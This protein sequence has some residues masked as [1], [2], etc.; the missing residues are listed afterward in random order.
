MTASLIAP[1]LILSIFEHQEPRFLIPLIVPLVYLNAHD[2]FPD[3]H[4]IVVATSKQIAKPAN[5]EKKPENPRHLLFK[6][7]LVLNVILSLFYGFIHQGGVFKATS[8]LSEELNSKPIN[9]NF[10][11]VTSHIYSMPKSLFLQKSSEKLYYNNKFKYKLNKRLFMYEEGSNNL[12]TVL[13]TL[14]ILRSSSNRTVIVYFVFP[15]S[16][17]V[18]IDYNLNN[19]GIKLENCVSFFPHVS[20][21]ALPTI[22]SFVPLNFSNFS[23]TF[24]SNFVKEL[25]NTLSIKICTVELIV[26]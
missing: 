4:N 8:Y 5:S 2:L 13:K 1:V 12:L 6:I 3:P 22:N 25:Y 7:W 16:L 21:E 23:V 24:V 11:V 20:T 9:T 15:N 26:S 10:H 14:E 19:I 17:K 18:E